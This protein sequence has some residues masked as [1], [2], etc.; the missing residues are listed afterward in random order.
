MIL[1]LRSTGEFCLEIFSDVSLCHEL[2]SLIDPFLF[3]E[4]SHCTVRLMFADNRHTPE[5]WR[6]SGTWVSVGE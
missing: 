5:T 4:N 2:L 1:K 6:P 3:L